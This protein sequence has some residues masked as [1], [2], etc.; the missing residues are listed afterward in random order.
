VSAVGKNAV[1]SHRTIGGKPV[2]LPLSGAAWTRSAA[3]TMADAF[4]VTPTLVAPLR[5]SAPQGILDGDTATVKASIGAAVLA[6]SD[7]DN[8]N[9]DEYSYFGKHPNPDPKD[10]SPW[11]ICGDFILLFVGSRKWQLT[12]TKARKVDVFFKALTVEKKDILCHKPPKIVRDRFDI[13]RQDVKKR[14]KWT[15]N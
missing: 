1:I 15:L 3:A 5:K 7:D 10:H 2:N 13:W 12:Y 11:D 9:D 8:D 4:E 6:N 14:R